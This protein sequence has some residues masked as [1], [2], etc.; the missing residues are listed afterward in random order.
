MVFSALCVC[1][2]SPAASTGPCKGT[3]GTAKFQVQVHQVLALLVRQMP[4]S[5]WCPPSLCLYLLFLL[6]TVLGVL[7]VRHRL[8]AGTQR[9]SASCYQKDL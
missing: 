4:S 1:C 5:R 9:L 8:A 6:M 3:E 7:D 2:A